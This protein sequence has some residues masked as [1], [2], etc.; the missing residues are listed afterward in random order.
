MKPENKKRLGWSLF[1][2]F[3]FMSL[4]IATYS[5]LDKRADSAL[6]IY[7]L[8]V[9]EGI[10]TASVLFGLCWLH[11]KASP[12]PNSDLVKAARFIAV[13]IILAWGKVSF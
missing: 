6:E 9:A 2:I 13:A 12:N 7:N 11:E 3:P 5:I 1:G 10:L 8:A 4:A